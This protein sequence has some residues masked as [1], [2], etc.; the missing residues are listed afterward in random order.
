MTP[1]VLVRF[2]VGVWIALV[3]F[4]LFGGVRSS[5]DQSADVV[6]SE[7]QGKP[8]HY[9]LTQDQI[10]SY[11][12]NGFIRLKNFFSPT[13]V[14]NLTA[15]MEEALLIRGPDWKFP[16]KGDADTCN[17]DFEYYNRVFTQRINLWS[18]NQKIKDFWHIYG[19]EIG[20]VAAELEGID[21]I[22]IWH[23]QALVKEP[24]A[25]PTSFHIDN[26][27]WP[28]NS[29]NAISIWMA[30][31]YVEAR[32]GALTFIPGSH[33]VIHEKEDPFEEIKIGKNVGEFFDHTPKLKTMDATVVNY[34]PGDVSFHNG[35]AVHGALPNYTPSRRRAFTCALM[36][37][38][39]IF[40]G[41]Q[42]VLTDEQFAKLR[43]GDE[44]NDIEINPML[45]PRV[46]FPEGLPN[47]PDS[48]M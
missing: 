28:F 7:D 19:N 34:E 32:N 27:Y 37:T 4:S 30:L 6:S 16:Q 35:L 42:N 29:K 1:K 10:Q 44:L 23:D 26:P 45:Y 47:L 38:G 46:E 21:G 43:I 2:F 24:W 22:H 31:D 12:D 17:V 11:R 25:N 36:P 33:K 9:D 13:E 8:F 39:S 3:S 5:I 18:T 40:N 41:K 15:A 14:A 48:Y 20:R